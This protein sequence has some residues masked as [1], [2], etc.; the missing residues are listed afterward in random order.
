MR[1]AVMEQFG[2]PLTIHEDWADPEC[3][4]R[5]AILEVGACGICRSDHTI[6]EGGAPWVGLVPELPSVLGHEYCG[7]VVEVGSEVTRFKK[8]DRVVAPF[9]HACGSCD[10]CSSGHQNV[11]ANVQVPSMH[12]TG[13][14]AS[15]AKVAHADVN[16]VTLPESID[17]ASAAG[18]GCRFITSYHGVV[19]VA[20]VQPGEWVAVF[21][22]GGVGLS[23]VNIA[24]S[25]GAQVIAVSRSEDKLQLAKEMGAVHTLKAGPDNPDEI[26]E[27]TG[28]GAHVTVDALGSAAT[29][30][31]GV[32]SLRSL[33]RHLRLGVSNHDEKGMINLPVDILVFQELS[34]LGSWGMQAAHFPEMLRQI[35]SGAL[36]PD[37]LVKDT[38][39]LD[40][41][42]DV[43]TSM[44]DYDT[45][46]MSVITEF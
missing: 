39:S 21:A 35:D 13:A 32:L 28:G 16:L 45:V 38:V 37:V 36:Q 25:L 27:L 11:C 34:F 33:G 17:F 5:D 10:F 7:T 20:K 8:G 41:A 24:A 23:A 4:P 46:G 42:S 1:A 44:G 31:P 3:G 40:E 26:R 9:N 15:H 19:D 18:L 12:Y 30:V 29:A 2:Q 43:L 14:Y 6:W 22:C